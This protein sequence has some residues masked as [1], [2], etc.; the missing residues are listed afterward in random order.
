MTARFADT[1]YFL[2]ILVPNDENHAA[3]V[4]LADWAGRLVTTDWILVETGNF[5]APQCSRRV[6]TQFV[7]TIVSE[8]RAT[9]V[10]ASSELLTRGIALYESRP[11]KDWSLTDCIS[12]IVMRDANL[13][14]A[15]T[16]DHHFTQAGFT[17][18]LK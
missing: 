13:T 3:A 4:K 16:A 8:T 18:L 2:A 12:F 14:D 7:R 10:Q 15:L 11:D 6:F 17:V 9:I 5:L 1:S